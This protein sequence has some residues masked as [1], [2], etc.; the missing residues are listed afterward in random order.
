MY[1][2]TRT[3][4]TIMPT[5]DANVIARVRGEAKGKTDMRE[6]VSYT[7]PNF[8]CGDSVSSDKLFPEMENL[9]KSP[10]RKKM[11]PP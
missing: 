9:R 7:L 10:F 6:P 1:E 2:P 8:F 3:E 11:I 5:I 4:T